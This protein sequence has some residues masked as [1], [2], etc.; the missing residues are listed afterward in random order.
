MVMYTA[1]DARKWSTR[2]REPLRVK[3]CWA[4][5]VDGKIVKADRGE[6]MLQTL[7]KR[8]RWRNKGFMTRCG[9]WLQALILLL[10]PWVQS[11]VV[12][13]E[14][15]TQLV[16]VRPFDALEAQWHV[17]FLLVQGAPSLSPLPPVDIA[18][19]N[20]AILNECSCLGRGRCIDFRRNPCRLVLGLAKVSCESRVY[21]GA[22]R[23]ESFGIRNL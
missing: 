12:C 7:G 3:I 5:L 20:G 11:A 8:S 22:N 21:H 9:W 6:A 19:V 16:L 23:T 18:S 10:L 13:R 1:T 4:F 2:R 14:A 15:V 17:S